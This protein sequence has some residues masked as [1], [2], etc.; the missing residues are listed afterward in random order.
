MGQVYKLNAYHSEREARARAALS[1][2]FARLI[3]TAMASGWS[4][5]EV[6]VY[7]ADIAEDNVLEVWQRNKSESLR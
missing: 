4:E 2:A 6:A 5:A 1:L 7:L 3:D